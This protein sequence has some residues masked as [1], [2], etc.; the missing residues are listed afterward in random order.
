MYMCL[1]DLCDALTTVYFRPV[2][3]NKLYFFVLLF[4]NVLKNASLFFK[5]LHDFNKDFIHS[6]L[7]LLVVEDPSRVQKVAP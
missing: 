2:G 3:L 5:L 1:Y 6:H 7:F 4:T